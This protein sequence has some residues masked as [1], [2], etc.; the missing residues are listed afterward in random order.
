MTSLQQG[1]HLINA[2]VAN[3]HKSVLRVKTVYCSIRNCCLVFI[4]VLK[5]VVLVKDKQ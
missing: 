1:R 3:I 2:H 5:I 4:I